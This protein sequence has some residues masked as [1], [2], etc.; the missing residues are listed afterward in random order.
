MRAGMRLTSRHVY[1]GSTPG[2]D[3]RLDQPVALRRP[4]TRVQPTEHASE[5][6]EPDPVAALEVAGRKRCGRAH[7]LLE[8]AHAARADVREAVEE[9]HD[10]RVP[11]RMSLVHDQPLPPRR[12]APVDRADPVSGDE[13]ADVRVLD[14]VALHAR[15]LASG[16][17]LRLERGEQR[18]KRRLCRVRLQPVVLLERCLP[19]HESEHV[20]CPQVDAPDVEDA[21]ARAPQAQWKVASF[22]CAKADRVGA[23][24]VDDLHSAGKLEEELQPVDGAIGARLEHGV[25]LGHLRRCDRRRA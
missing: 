17:R 21:P 12:G 5:A 22:A 2:L 23:R 16:E 15:H 7:G 11:L 19:R 14:A 6:D 18:L 24:A 1:V 10:V 20:A 13:V 8:D 25:D 3:H 4:H 9:E